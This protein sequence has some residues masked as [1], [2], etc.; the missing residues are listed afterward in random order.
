M[1][2]Y[3]VHT[4]RL[5]RPVTHMQRYL[6]DRHAV[7]SDRFQNIRRKMQ[8]RRR[9]RDRPALARKNGLIPFAIRVNRVRFTFYI[10]RQRR[11]PDLVKDLIKVAIGFKPDLDPPL[12]RFLYHL[13]R[14]PFAKY[15]PLTYM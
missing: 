10:R 2:A 9:S 15:D 1:L 14:Q 11:P 8:P 5:K 13:R 3:V 4:N 6:C 7:V 12:I